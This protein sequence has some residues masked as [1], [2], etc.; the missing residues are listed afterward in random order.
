MH[1]YYDC[2][3][4]FSVDECFLFVPSIYIT[5]IFLSNRKSVIFIQRTQG[6]QTDI[7]YVREYLSQ[8]AL[9]PKACANVKT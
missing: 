1:N 6:A 4:F 5:N 8:P 2:F 7:H 9:L 3:G